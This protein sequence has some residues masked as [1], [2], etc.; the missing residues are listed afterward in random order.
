MLICFIVSKGKQRKW[1]WWER[2]LRV[3]LGV[4]ERPRRDDQT[5]EHDRS[6]QTQ[7]RTTSKRRQASASHGEFGLASPARKPLPTN[8][9][10]LSLTPPSWTSSRGTPH[11]PCNLHLI[12]PFPLPLHQ[13]DGKNQLLEAWFLEN[14]PPANENWCKR[15]E[16][17]PCTTP[18]SIPLQITRKKNCIQDL[19]AISGICH[20]KKIVWCWRYYVGNGDLLCEISQI[21]LVILV[22]KMNF[23]S[24]MWK[25]AEPWYVENCHGEYHRKRV[26]EER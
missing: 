19:D 22:K 11:S 21:F 17:S 6:S 24:V 12:L 23:P 1:I 4:N 5:R 13:W 25:E 8:T 26:G 16:Q 18:P 3:D 7:L 10:P 15:V 2:S 20:G 14:L 9:N